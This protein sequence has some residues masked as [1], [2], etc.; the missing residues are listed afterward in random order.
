M[1]TRFLIYVLAVISL[2]SCSAFAKFQEAQVIADALVGDPK[3][4]NAQAPLTAGTENLP[5]YTNKLMLRNDLSLCFPVTHSCDQHCKPLPDHN[6]VVALEGKSDA[7][8]SFKWSF[9]DPINAEGVRAV[10]KADFAKSHKVS[11]FYA[12]Q[13]RNT[14]VGY[15]N[16]IRLSD[17]LFRQIKAGQA[18]EF[19]TDGPYSPMVNHKESVPLPHYL[20]AVGRETVPVMV[21]EKKVSVRAIQAQANNGWTYSILDNPKFPILLKG[22]GP[23][24]WEPPIFVYA[25]GLAGDN[26]GMREGKRIVKDLKNN[27]IATT[28]AIQFDFDS[29]KLRPAAK[30]ILNE[31]AKYMAA[32]PGIKIEVQGHTCTI[33]TA[34][35]NMSLSDRRAKA[36]RDYLVNA[37]VDS[38]RLQP[39]GFGFNKPVAS[40]ATNAGRE[41]NRRVVFRI[42]AR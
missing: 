40:N 5:D 26:S 27:G 34:A 32:N 9:T 39:I 23:F 21:D 8:Y 3:A 38:S 1:K 7:A 37:G 17:E 13:Q 10:D 16:A 22:T 41:K 14:L 42:T 6:M 11:F 4:G 24:V 31:I 33:G 12:N 36:V 30:P 15:T 19:E 35:Y 25:N 28:N 18:A 2:F 20:K 29:A